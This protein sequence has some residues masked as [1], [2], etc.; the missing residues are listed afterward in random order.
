MN[1][2]YTGK[3]AS[4]YNRTWRT[5]LQKTLSA[6]LSA[7]DAEALQQRASTLERPLRILD[8]ACG[9]G[10]LLE[11]F[12][13]LLPLAELYGIDES[14]AMLAQALCRDAGFQVVLAKPFQINLFCQGWVLCTL[15][16]EHDFAERDG[17]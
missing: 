7:I 10:L 5:F 2:Y 15:P 6:T 14:Q 13:H 16:F 4:R 17:C 8:A 1:T 12:T 9:T 3:H 11:Q